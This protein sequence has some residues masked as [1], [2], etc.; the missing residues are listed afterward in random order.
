MEQSYGK[1]EVRGRDDHKVYDASRTIVLNIS[2]TLM[3]PN[4]ALI[5]RATITTNA[6]ESGIVW[7]SEVNCST[8]TEKTVPAY[9]KFKMICVIKVHSTITGISRNAILL[10]LVQ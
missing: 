3:V 2:G 6:S 4:A 9:L 7:A 10:Y 5:A 1:H 8:L